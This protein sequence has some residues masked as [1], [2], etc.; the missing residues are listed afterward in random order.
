[1]LLSALLSGCSAEGPTRLVSSHE[2]YNDAVHLVTSREVLKNVVRM[3][4]LDP[5]QFVY[6]SAINAQF[7]VSTGANVG[8]TFG[9]GAAAAGTAGGNVGF[10]D[11]PTIT[12]TP[13][14]GADAM[15]S[16]E[17]P[18]DLHLL[19]NYALERDEPDTV[20]IAS[21]FV[22][23]N[24]APDAPGEKGELFRQRVAALQRLMELGCRLS[25]RTILYPRH[26]PFSA[27]QIHARAYV[28][29]AAKNLYF[30]DVLGDGRLSVASKHVLPGLFVPEPDD[31][32]V[33]EQLRII[34]A[35]PG[36]E[37]YF[38]R[39]PSQLQVPNSLWSPNPDG[40]VAASIYVIP[41]SVMSLMA[42]AS[43]TVQT[44]PDHEKRG[45]APPLSAVPTNTSLELPMRIKSS[46][47][48]PS[49]EYRISHR[50]FWFSIDDK[51]HAS[52]RIFG[53]MVYAYS[54][55][56]GGKAPAVPTLTLPIG[57]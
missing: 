21:A 49:D 54:H 28:D 11:S 56:L 57:G 40:R 4:Y 42:A 14:A 9:G 41:R 16:L 52:K 45:I 34:D 20:E 47:D 39:P 33:I 48:E 15:R 2:S 30:V 10:S 25:Q 36:I 24:N 13:V 38:L 1:L 55:T 19:L 18:V 44:P 5:V 7:S 29:A 35:E 6:V 53:Q 23:I 3:R 22:A 8:T 50:G 32:R 51:D 17:S 12:F 46:M 31:P 37:F 27:E 43:R 26:E